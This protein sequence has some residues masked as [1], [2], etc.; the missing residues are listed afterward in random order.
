M[1]PEAESYLSFSHYDDPEA[2]QVTMTPVHAGFLQ[3]FASTPGPV[4][5]INSILAGAFASILAAGVL[6]LTVFPVIVIGVLVLVLAIGLHAQT[7]ARI[8]PR[9]TREHMDVRFPT[10][11]E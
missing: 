3:G 2:V 10:P 9:K 1:A 6:S 5:L 4:I 11:E 8:W 7:A